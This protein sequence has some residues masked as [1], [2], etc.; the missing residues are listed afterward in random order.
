MTYTEV[1]DNSPLSPF[2][3][4]VMIGCVL[5]QILDGFDFQSTSFALPLFSREFHLNPAQ[6]GLVSAVTNVGLLVGALVFAPIADRYGRRPVFQWALF[7]YAFGTLLSGLAPSYNFL[8][9]VR[10]ITGVGI[11]AEFPVALALLAEY[12]PRRLRHIFVAAGSIGYSFGWFVCAVVA[13]AVVPRFGWRF[14]YFLGVVPALMILYVRRHVPESVRYLCTRGKM[15]EAEAIARRVADQAG[16][17]DVILV[18]PP[19]RVIEKNDLGKQLSAIR[20]FLAALVVLALFQLANNIQIVGIGTWLP[21]IF[22]KQGFNLRA[23]FSFTMIVLTMTP[24]G[25]IGAIWLQGRMPRKWAIF[26][27]CLVGALCFVVAGLSFEFHY[28][29]AATIVCMVAYQ[30]FSGGTVPIII[31]LNVELFPT[32]V[33][34]LAYGL[35]VACARI[36]SISGPLVLGVMLNLGTEIHQ[37]IYYFSVPLVLAAFLLVIF[38]KVDPRQRSLEEVTGH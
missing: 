1:I 33:R 6:A 10:F 9:L 16:F 26:L 12:S 37:I 4:L 21:S 34:S 28:P 24:L 31:T 17:T 18:P 30:F 38:I 25:Q 29:I 20:P 14:L 19:T 32:Q 11:A 27:L 7:L 23:S 3:W 5:A 35:V 2:L 15:K 22:M 13:T 8:L 36:G